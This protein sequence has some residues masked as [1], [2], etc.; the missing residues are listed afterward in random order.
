VGTE[1][2]DI[3]LWVRQAASFAEVMVSTALA[4]SVY[5]GAGDVPL[6]GSEP[7]RTWHYVKKIL[8]VQTQLAVFHLLALQAKPR[9]KQVNCKLSSQTMGLA[10]AVAQGQMEKVVSV[11]GVQRKVPK[12][13]RKICRTAGTKHLR[14]DPELTLRAAHSSDPNSFIIIVDRSF[15]YYSSRQMWQKWCCKPFNTI[16]NTVHICCVLMARVNASA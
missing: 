4:T 16:R 6:R 1:V 15:L 7:P 13:L 8:D 5:R 14:R 9:T 11:G 2:R 12:Q 10:G 3:Y